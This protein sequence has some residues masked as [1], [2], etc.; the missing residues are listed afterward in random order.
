MTGSSTGPSRIR[1]SVATKLLVSF[2][3]LTILSFGVIGY[4]AI[5]T[6]NEIG[7][8]AEES[9]KKL[10]NDAARD[11]TLA[12]KAQGEAS[13]KQKGTDVSKQVEIYMKSHPGTFSGALD[14]DA[15]LAAIAV[16]SV[17]RTG[18]TALYEKHTGIMRLHPNPALVNFDM[19]NLKDQL[20]SMWKIYD[21]SIDGSVAYGYYD[22]AEPDGSIRQKFMYMLPVEGYDYMVAA[23]TYIDEFTEPVVATRA[24]IDAETAYASDYIRQKIQSTLLVFI[25]SFSLVLLLAALLIIVIARRITN[26][27]RKLAY[28]AGIIGEGNLDYRVEVKTGDELENLAGSFNKM[29]SDLKGHTEELLRTSAEKER[30]AKELDIAR[31][32]QQSFLPEFPPLIKGI[33]IAA[34]NL[35]AREVGGDF[36]DFIPIGEDKWGLVIADVSGKGVPAALF[37]A[38]S[39]TLVRAN[40]VGDIS[41]VE[42]IRR[43]NDLIAEH[44][45]ASM[46]VTLFYGVL[47][48]VKMTLTYVSA[49][50]NPSLMLKSGSSDVVLMRAEGIALGVLRDIKLEV[51]EISLDSGDVVLLYTDGVTEAINASEEQ[52]GVQRLCELSQQ[53]VNLSAEDIIKR[54]E[55]T[56]V[57]FSGDQP[58][59]DDF[60]LMVLKIL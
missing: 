43:A 15:E 42:T 20:P 38:L 56:V 28:G 45:R 19:H 41:V 25:I 40:A 9:S 12:L 13:I 23:T 55:Q 50:H 49:G 3:L 32:I 31:N 37:M 48:P 27:L 29:A 39:R 22:W 4:L 53:S 16:Q 5:S 57:D 58:Q 1:W 24:A 34:M 18:Y 26:P 59:F 10:G 52:F 2:L 8:F 51:K 47:D 21:A 60:T 54:I 46:F 36:Y 35:P 30:I 14:K 17:G 6:L 7:V 11:S 33:E 44:D